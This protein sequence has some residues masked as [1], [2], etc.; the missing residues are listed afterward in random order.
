[1]K[2]VSLLKTWECQ[3]VNIDKVNRSL[4]HMVSWDFEGRRN[5][6]LL[7]GLIYMYILLFIYSDMNFNIIVIVCEIQSSYPVNM[8][9]NLPALFGR[10]VAEFEYCCVV[11]SNAVGRGVPNSFD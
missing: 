5:V 8:V 4:F 2:G 7:H 3:G 6:T 10:P 1:M 9:F 11:W